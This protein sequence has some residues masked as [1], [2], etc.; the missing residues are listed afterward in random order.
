MSPQEAQQPLFSARCVRAGQRGRYLAFGGTSRLAVFSDRIEIDG[1]AIH[2]PYLLRL[3]AM[4]RLGEYPNVL[5]IAYAAAGGTPVERWFSFQSFVPGRAK[6]QLD[7]MCFQIRRARSEFDG[8]AAT[9]TDQANPRAQTAQATVV[10]PAARR[11]A[12]L[13]DVGNRPAVV[14][15]SSRVAF[16]SCCPTCG[17]DA[18]TVAT[19]GVSS[20]LFRFLPGGAL[21]A[22]FVPV[23]VA[24]RLLGEAIVVEQWSVESSDVHFSFSS[25][26]Y[27]ERFLAAN[28]AEPQIESGPSALASEVTSGTRFVLYLYAVGL[29]VFWIFRF[30]DVRAVPPGAR[31][32]AAGLRY[33]LLTA[34]L[35]W[36]AIQSIIPAIRALVENFKGGIDVSSNVLAVARCEALSPH[37][38]DVLGSPRSYWWSRG[39]MTQDLVL[40]RDDS[41]PYAE[42]QAAMARLREAE[43]RAA[44]TAESHP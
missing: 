34:F 20:G 9:P 21:A 4:P 36:W 28:S 7:E 22:W 19:L 29:I 32:R 10:A 24:H 16:P 41:A 30:S 5:E 43:D 17:A 35:G 6:R 37:R 15:H 40:S 2:Y 1:V 13:A 18:R 25:A 3:E 23:C 11:S 44:R 38:G 39:I 12:R 8:G 31:R 14:V 26:A 27:A 33:S 42:L